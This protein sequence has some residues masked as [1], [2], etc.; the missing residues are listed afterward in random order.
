MQCTIYSTQYRGGNKTEFLGVDSGIVGAA[1]AIAFDWLGRNLYIGNC[2]ASNLE[3][4]KVD[5]KMKYRAVILANNGNAVSVAKPK[6]ICL[7]PNEG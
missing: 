5:S 3:L 6:S 2:I 1:Y 4:V 7:D